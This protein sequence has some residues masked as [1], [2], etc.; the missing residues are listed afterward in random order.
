[1]RSKSWW[2]TPAARRLM[3]GTGIVFQFLPFGCSQNI[4]R[5]VTPVLLDDTVNILDNVI[6]AVAPLVLR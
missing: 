4:L 2:T 1:M 3:I 6:T 5:L